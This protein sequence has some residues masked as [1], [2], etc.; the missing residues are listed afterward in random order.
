MRGTG[1]N[2]ID[3]HKV[4]NK[5]ELLNNYQWLRN[6]TRDSVFDKNFVSRLMVGKYKNEICGIPLL[7]DVIS[8]HHYSLIIEKIQPKTVIDLGTAFGGSSL[9]FTTKIQDDCKVLTLDIEDIRK[10]DEHPQVMFY[11]IDICDEKGMNNI[12]K[13]CKHPWLISEDCHVPANQIMK[14]FKPLMKN[15]D[16]IVFEDTHLCNPEKCGM[17]AET[18]YTVGTWS[19]NKLDQVEKEMLQY[20]DIMIDAHIQDFYGYN[21]CTHIN[22]V[23]VHM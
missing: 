17:S 15:G 13:N 16:Y 5:E 14:V 8:M 6:R 9:W 20:D 2:A 18:D 12:L 19:K 4:L 23:F 1:Q 22:S 3:L 10:T 11:K 7:K 21:G